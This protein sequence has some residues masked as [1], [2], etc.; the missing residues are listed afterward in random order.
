M[1]HRGVCGHAVWP[2]HAPATLASVCKSL[3]ADYAVCKAG[4]R[5]HHSRQALSSIISASCAATA[6]ASFHL[7]PSHCVPIHG[8]RPNICRCELGATLCQW[9]QVLPARSQTDTGQ[10]SDSQQLER[11]APCCSG[12]DLRSDTPSQALL[13]VQQVLQLE[14]INAADEQD[15]LTPKRDPSAKT[16]GLTAN[17]GVARPSSEGA[18]HRGPSPGKQTACAAAAAQGNKVSC[19]CASPIQVVEACATPPEDLQVDDAGAL[20]T[21]VGTLLLAH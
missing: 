4:L 12:L 7:L 17:S 5:V 10:T 19:P 1:H 3:I 21:F 8:R 6:L 9:R 18:T 16:G 15:H 14:P 11:L 20:T 13:L 2:S